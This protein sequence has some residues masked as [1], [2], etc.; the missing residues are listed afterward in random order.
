[1]LHIQ[2]FIDRV[3]GCDIRNQRDFVMTLREAKDLHT[4][5]T[6]LMMELLKLKETAQKPQEEVIKV[7]LTG[8]SF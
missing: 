3:Q 4:D 2:Q 1:M 5:I 8:G 6:K 7:E